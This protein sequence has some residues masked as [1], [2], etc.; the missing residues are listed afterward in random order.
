M[1][2]KQVVQN[3]LHALDVGRG[4]AVVAAFD[5]GRLTSDAGALLLG[6]AVAAG[7]PT[8]H[9]QTPVNYPTQ[10]VTLVVP[11]PAGGPP[12]IT[13]SPKPMVRATAGVIRSG[14]TRHQK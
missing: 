8:A 3:S 13:S 10:T 12:D 2:K 7:A 5:G 6:A 11:F 1:S 9:A 4:A 14:R